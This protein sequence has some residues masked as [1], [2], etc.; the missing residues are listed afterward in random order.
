MKADAVFEGGGVRGIAL[1]GAIQLFEDAGYAWQRVAGTSVG[2]IV[3][4]LIASGYT[5]AELKSIITSMNYRKLLGK[6]V[7]NRIPLVG[8]G[9]SLLFKLG[10]YVNEPLE[11]WLSEL[12][13]RKNVHTFSDLP[14]GKLTI[15]ASDISNGKMLVLPDDLHDY[16]IS[17]DQF[18]I[19]TA[20]RMSTSIP[21][22]FQPYRWRPPISIRPT[23]VVDG[24]I[25]SNYPIWIFDT[26]GVP[27]W[28]T[29]GFKLSERT[30]IANPNRIH[31]PFSLSR[32]LFKTM[33]QAHDQRH[34]DEHGKSRTIFIPTGKITT[35]QFSLGPDEIAFLR[36]SGTRAAEKFLANWD[37]AEYKSKFRST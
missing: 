8:G 16:G 18:P 30:T 5:A 37:F 34:V 19:A 12:L 2:A 3:A 25:L 33:L 28:P 36:Y 29:F 6:G 32:A 26:A 24:G 20:V 1:A 23:Y 31:G 27:R 22:F 10:L 15:I 13:Q 21:F 14:R 17:P 11:Q 7:L 4:S 9:L 35:T